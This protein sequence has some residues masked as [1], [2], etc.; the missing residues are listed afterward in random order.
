MPARCVP[1]RED[2][3]VFLTIALVP[4]LAFCLSLSLILPGRSKKRGKNCPTAILDCS[5][6]VARNEKPIIGTGENIEVSSFLR[7]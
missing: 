4:Y 5:D 7:Y 3:N 2:K 6:T 1:Y